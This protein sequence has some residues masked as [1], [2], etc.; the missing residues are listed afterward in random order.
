MKLKMLM[1]VTTMMKVSVT[2][3]IAVTIRI[4]A[5]SGVSVR[6][7]WA[8]VLLRFVPELNNLFN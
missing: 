5:I 4:Q 7:V 1:T 8:E 3:M 6:Y 2:V